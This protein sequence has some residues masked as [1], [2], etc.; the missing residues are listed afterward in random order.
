MNDRVCEKC[1]NWDQTKS[2]SGGLC[3]KYAPKAMKKDN[4]GQFGIFWPR[5]LPT[6]W[7]GEFKDKPSG[8]GATS[9]GV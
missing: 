6:D 4:Q 3:R 5:T 1:C 2:G 7:C 8:R 9:Q